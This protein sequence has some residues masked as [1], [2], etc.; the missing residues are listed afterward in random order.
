MR[1]REPSDL[2]T[3]RQQ[4]TGSSPTLDLAQLGRIAECHTRVFKIDK[5]RIITCSFGDM[6]DLAATR[7]LHAERRQG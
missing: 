7:N 1:Q 4:F 5:K 6:R 3:A 2:A